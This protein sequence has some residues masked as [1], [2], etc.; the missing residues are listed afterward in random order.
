MKTLYIK[1]LSETA[2][3][4]YASATNNKPGDAGFDL[5]FMED[6]IFEPYNLIQLISF[7][8]SIYVEDEKGNNVGV[9]IT[10]RSS[11]YKTPF[12]Q[13]N[14]IGIIDAGYRGDLMCPVEVTSQ[15]RNKTYALS[16]DAKKCFNDHM[17]DSRFGAL[18]DSV[19]DNSVYYKKHADYNYVPF[20]PSKSRLFQIVDPGMQ[21]FNVVLLNE[22]ED[23]PSSV[24]GSDS[25]GSTGF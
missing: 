1:P 23:L 25:F 10:P 20:I 24:R 16:L 17:D 21:G 18:V 4:Y 12:R 3:N 22:G 14:S 2:R 13:A 11:I 5:A 8:I 15:H 6:V 7:E 19:L 9:L